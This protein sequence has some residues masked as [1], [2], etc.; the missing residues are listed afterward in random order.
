MKHSGLSILLILLVLVSTGCTMKS[1]SIAHTHVGHALTAW[2]NT[3]DQKG[4][5][6]VAEDQAREA[7]EA[8]DQLSS[9]GTDLAGIKTELD[10]IMNANDPQNTDSAA[11]KAEPPYGVKQAVVGAVDHITF[12]ANSAD[13]T[14]N[15]KQF[16]PGFSENSTAILERC[17]LITVLGED[18]RAS[19]S[20]EEA[21]I[22]A[23]EVISLAKSNLMGN[24]EDNDGVIGNTPE[25]YGVLQL[26]ADLETMLEREDPP[27]STV[28]RWYVLNL[29]QLPTGEWAFKSRSEEGNGGGG[30]G[31]GGGGY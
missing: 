31:G 11:I 29:I 20:A 1:P 16:V 2:Q 13:A 12:A 7:A 14:P 18:I 3:P 9:Q 28:S 8:A 26:R 22:L 19:Q 5:L 24:D 6:V 30:G 10:K 15:L 17:D 23:Q 25:E 27:Y 4:L 21:E